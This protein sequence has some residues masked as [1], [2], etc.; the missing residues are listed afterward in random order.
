MVTCQDA[1]L[2]SEDEGNTLPHGVASGGLF[3]AEYFPCLGAYN[4][5]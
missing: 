2:S 1:S 5:P 4:P 3:N